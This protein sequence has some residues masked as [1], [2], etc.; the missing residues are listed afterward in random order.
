MLERR[1]LGGRRVRGPLTPRGQDALVTAGKMPA[2][3]TTASK[4]KAT[5]ADGLCNHVKT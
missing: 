4:A 3:P 5:V 1:Q 2:L